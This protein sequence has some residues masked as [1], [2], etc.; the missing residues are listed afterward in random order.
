MK[1]AQQIFDKTLHHL[2]KQGVAAIDEN[3]K[4]S[5]RTESGASCAVGCHIPDAKYSPSLEGKRA[6]A[7]KVLEATGFIGQG[8]GVLLNHLQAC[9]DAH[10][11]GQGLEAWETV[12]QDVALQHG[13]TYKP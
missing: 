2:R 12:M 1:T 13:L 5:Y 11:K 3:G 4:C 8:H 9:H 10:L 6:N 7:S